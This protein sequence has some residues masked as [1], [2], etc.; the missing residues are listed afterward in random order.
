VCGV[1]VTRT[2]RI[3]YRAPWRGTIGRTDNKGLEARTDRVWRSCLT[4]HNAVA[5]S[6]IGIPQSRF[7]LVANDERSMHV[8][9][10]LLQLLCR[11]AG[12]V[13]HHLAIEQV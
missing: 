10:A 2:P 7:L 11:L 12:L 4:T 5:C 3:D 1:M 6:A 9:P 13:A 8:E